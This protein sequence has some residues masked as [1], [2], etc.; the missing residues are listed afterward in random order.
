MGQIVVEYHSLGKL[1]TKGPLY[2]KAVKKIEKAGFAVAHLHGNN[3]NN[4]HGNG[5]VSFGPYKIPN[6]L[7]VTY[8]KK[9]PAEACAVDVPYHVPQDRP[10]IKR[11][12]ELPDAVLPSKYASLFTALG[13]TPL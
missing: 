1:L 7:E 3:Y 5:M 6:I 13:T 4:K 8:V 9:P 12:P 11:F 10:N 2:L